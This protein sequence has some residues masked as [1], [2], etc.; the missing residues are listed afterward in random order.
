MKGAKM[1]FLI[2]IASKYIYRPARLLVAQC[3]SLAVRLSDEVVTL[4]PAGTELQVSCLGR[5]TAR[6]CLT[7]PG[8][9]SEQEA[10]SYGN[11]SFG[12][13]DYQAGS[14]TG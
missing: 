9:E 13:T 8:T 4:A 14:D 12:Q 10:S 6:G 11:L 3:L 7:T 5:T 2:V 1:L